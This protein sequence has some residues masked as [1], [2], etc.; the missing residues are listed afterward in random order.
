VELKIALA[1]LESVEGLSS[2][3]VG[4]GLM[5]HMFEFKWNE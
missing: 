2:F 1:E 5:S 3:V 4:H